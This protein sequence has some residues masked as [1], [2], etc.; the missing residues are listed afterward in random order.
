MSNAA[1][2]RRAMPIYLKRPA[3]CGECGARLP[4]GCL[5]RWYR[6]G[7]VFGLTCHGEGKTA[8]VP[9]SGRDMAAG[10]NTFTGSVN[11]C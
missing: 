9:L 2:G 7:A 4:V 11:K 5:A 3:I 6:T 8:P 10:E 1:K